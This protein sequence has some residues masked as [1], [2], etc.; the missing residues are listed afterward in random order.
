ML[1]RTGMLSWIGAFAF[2]TVTAVL[3]DMPERRWFKLWKLW[4][5][6]PNE[7]WYGKCKAVVEVIHLICIGD[8]LKLQNSRLEHPKVWGVGGASIS[9]EPVLWGRPVSSQC[10]TIKGFLQYRSSGLDPDSAGHLSGCLKLN[11][12]RAWLNQGLRKKMIAIIYVWLPKIHSCLNQWF[13]RL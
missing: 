9:L 13:I 12:W 6:S 3:I 8:G 7:Q 2:V 11:M 10:D 1:S 4:L 5:C